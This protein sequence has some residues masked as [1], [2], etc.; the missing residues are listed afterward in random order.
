M[1][2]FGHIGYYLKIWIIVVFIN[3]DKPKK[4]Y[5]IVNPNIRRIPKKYWRTIPRSIIQEMVDL[6]G[7]VIEMKKKV[8]L[9]E[10]DLDRHAKCLCISELNSLF[11]SMFYSRPL[12][13]F[14]D[15]SAIKWVN[16]LLLPLDENRI[17]IY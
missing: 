2:I 16:W 8:L 4:E 14:E 9:V 12:Q 5:F 13:V 7:Q 10:S 11:P 3:M 17:S 6:A 15:K 1:A